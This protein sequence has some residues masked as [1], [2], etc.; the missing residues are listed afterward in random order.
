MVDDAAVGAG[1]CGEVRGGGSGGIGGTAGFALR[2]WF[3][4]FGGPTDE[5]V[6]GMGQFIDLYL[7]KKWNEISWE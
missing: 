1:Y 4:V 6:L 3:E 2:L 7:G 5:I